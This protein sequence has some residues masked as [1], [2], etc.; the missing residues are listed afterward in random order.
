MGQEAMGEVA[1]VVVQAAVMVV[2]VR[3][4]VGWAAVEQA[5]VM[6]ADLEAVVRVEVGSEVGG[7]LVVPLVGVVVVEGLAVA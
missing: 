6:E 3:G 5:A 1:Q 7:S 4:G 2:A